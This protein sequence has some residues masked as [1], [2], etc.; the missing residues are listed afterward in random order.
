MIAIRPRTTVATAALVALLAALGALPTACS[1]NPATGRPQLALYSTQQEI[2][3]GRRAHREVLASMGAY[4][5]PA[6]QA[7]VARI[8]NELAQVSERPDLPWT[9]TVIDDPSVNAFALPG[10]FVYL[11]RGILGY[12]GSEAEMVSVLGHEIGHVTARHAVERMSKAELASLGLTA[13]MILS[14]GLRD[15]GEVAQTGLGVLFLKFSRD[16]ERQADDLGFR[17]LNRAGYDPREMVAMFRVLERVSQ[18]SPAG[19]LPDWLATH[20]NPTDRLERIQAEIEAEPREL[21]GAAVKRSAYLQRIDGLVFGEDP[22]QGYFQETTFYQPQLAVRITFPAGWQTSNQRQ[23]VGAVSPK[24]DAVVALSLATDSS[25]AEAARRFFGQEGVEQGSGWRA[26]VGGLPAVASAFRLDRGASGHVDGLVAFVA[27]RDKVFQ[28]LGYSLSD[29]YSRYQEEIAAS[30]ASFAPLTDPRYLRVEPK[31][32]ALVTL[33][34]D[35][36][37]EDF[38]AAFPSTVPAETLA[39]LNHVEPG[40][41]L[42]VGTEAKRVVGG[43]LP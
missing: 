19:R 8:G 1:S 25:P 34:R 43:A 28:L 40:E 3:I 22:R 32:L 26:S 5:D 10:G 9:F 27:D 24:Q 4:P 16:D 6:L 11:T 14:P 15:Y 7:Y 38:Q 36:R 30:L 41:I 39:I 18:G 33:P 23:T 31:R 13:G 12:M 42:R 35:M 20:P 21:L 29:H 2:E 17:Y 37:L